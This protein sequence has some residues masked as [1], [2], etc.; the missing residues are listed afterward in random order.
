M[1]QIE[2]ISW[3]TL[4]AIKQAANILETVGDL[5]TNEQMAV[6]CS[7]EEDFFEL[8]Y[9]ELE[10]N[11]IRHFEDEEEL[12]KF[13]DIRKNEFGEEDYDTV[14]YYDDDDDSFDD[15]EEDDYSDYKIRDSEED[16][17]F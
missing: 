8:Y 11:Y 13:L 7:I 9:S 12:Y 3:K 1:E 17:D 14:D 16:E 5:D 4:D 15:A 10:S 2:V 6:F